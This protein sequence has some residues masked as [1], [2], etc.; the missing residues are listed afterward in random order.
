VDKGWNLLSTT[1][2][3]TLSAEIIGQ[4]VISVWAWQEAGEAG[5]GWSVYLTGDGTAT[6]AA[7]KGFSVLKS[8]QAREGFWLN[9][10]ADKTTLAIDGPL[11]TP[12]LSPTP[13]W[14]LLGRV[15]TESSSLTE[16]E[17][18]LSAWAWRENDQGTKT[19]AVY[20]PEGK[21]PDYANSK[22]FLPLDL[23]TISIGEGFW[24]NLQQ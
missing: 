21:G 19:W 13:G 16:L 14:N 17:P 24:L 12:A 10:Q 18:V 2:P 15:T 9:S 22:G 20:L 1:I 8:I 3:F 5:K 6:Y 4:E 7:A 11:G 23:D